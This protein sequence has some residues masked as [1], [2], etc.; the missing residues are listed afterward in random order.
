MKT[1]DLP[2]TVPKV[3]QHE[4]C[5]NLQKSVQYSMKRINCDLNV[6]NSIRE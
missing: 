4:L 1:P 2:S 5:L 6:N 3:E